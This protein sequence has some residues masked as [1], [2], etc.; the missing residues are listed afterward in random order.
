[1][2][3]SVY[4]ASVLICLPYLSELIDGEALAAGLLNAG[5]GGC[6]EAESSNAQLGDFEEATRCVS[7]NYTAEFS[8]VPLYRV[9]SVIFA[10]TT[11]VFALLASALPFGA[12][13]A[14]MRDR[15][16]GGPSKLKSAPD[17]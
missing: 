7:E 4:I 17:N 9:S 15:D 12:A 8:I 1:V 10:I 13:F 3:W 11:T 14:T 2:F 6:G 5:T 16:T